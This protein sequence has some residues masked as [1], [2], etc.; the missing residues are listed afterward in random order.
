M[1]DPS[2]GTCT[3]T[4]EEHSCTPNLSQ[5]CSAQCNEPISGGGDRSHNPTPLHHLPRPPPARF[6]VLLKIKAIIYSQLHISVGKTSSLQCRFENIPLSKV[7][8]C[9]LEPSCAGWDVLGDTA[10]PSLRHS[11]ALW[12]NGRQRC[13]AAGG[14]MGSSLPRKGCLFIFPALVLGSC[15]KA[16]V[17]TPSQPLHFRVC[18]ISFRFMLTFTIW[19]N[20]NQLLSALCLQQHPGQAPAPLSLVFSTHGAG[21]FTAKQ[22]LCKTAAAARRGIASSC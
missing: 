19:L 11:N 2:S 14:H 16:E 12:C 21:D 22:E 7:K 8:L 5:L 20:T 15:S 17:L 6:T 9:E 18:F 10:V 3:G 13:P 4:R 1:H